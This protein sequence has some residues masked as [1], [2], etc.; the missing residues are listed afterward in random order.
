MREVRFSF[1]LKSTD[2]SSFPCIY[3]MPIQLNS[4]YT[5]TFDGLARSGSD[6]AWSNHVTLPGWYL[7]R[8]PAPGTEITAYTANHGSSNVGS[9]MSYGA[10]EDSD[11]ALGALGSGGT[12][13][14]SPATGNIA[15]WIA[16]AATNATGGTLE[17]ITLAFDGE[18][19][20]NGGN[21]TPQTMVLEYGFGASFGAVATWTAPG[22]TF[23][24]TSPIATTTAG[25]VDGNTAGRVAD[26][27]GTL[28]ALGWAAGETLW[29]RWREVNDAG[30][31]HGLAIDN[32]SL[33]LPA[34]PIPTVSLWVST[35]V[36][37]EA[38][39]TVITVTAIASAA[40]VG[41]QSVQLEV[42]GVGITATDYQLSSPTI[43]ILDGQTSGTVTFT[44]EDDGI[45]EGPEVATLTLS[46]PSAGLTLGDS[47]TQDIA[48]T[49][50]AIAGGDRSGAGGRQTF[51]FTLGDIA[52]IH[53]FGGVGP[54]AAPSRDRRPEV[55]TLVFS[56]AGLTARNL[57]L[58]QVGSDVVV[59]FAAIASPRI[60]LTNIALDHVDN[61]RLGQQIWAN[62]QFKGQAR[63]RATLTVLAADA[64]PRRISQRNGV[65][66]LNDLDNR[67]RGRHDS[68]DVINGQGGNDRLRGRRGNDLLRGGEGDDRLWGN[69]GHDV[70]LGED[71]D[72]LLAG[73]WGADRL[74]GGAGSDTFR[75]GDRRHSRLRHLDQIT[76][77]E[78]G[79][80]RITAPIA[81]A[82]SEVAQLGE[83]ST[84]TQR[85]IA[86]VL[87]QSDF[88]ARG[89]ATFTLGS[90]TFLALNDGTAGFQH[91]R[92][93]L[94][95]I[96]GFTG[97]LSTLEIEAL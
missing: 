27:G 53:D 22:G 19:W 94:I 51:T 33:T 64:T 88:A 60:T 73:G 82:A 62:F 40:V 25:A 5:Q 7:F 3:P 57:Q 11:R 79:I 65:T 86:A 47:I 54:G 84:L 8:Q 39:Q 43:I 42:S 95:E 66:I 36:G 15:G 30:N 41:D 28:T 13:F 96:T 75:Y 78:I 20:R 6:N 48:I 31:D 23:D 89:A 2:P 37:A 12:Y 68:H 16:F 14:G 35:N 61:L 71:G 21:A 77:L 18:Q 49:D 50:N 56:G 74:T 34:V 91:R 38:E 85:A 52:T 63:P 80:D 72:D 76:D 32:F 90:R 24:W 1:I 29:L 81:V 44:L 69:R 46:N 83:V 92:D 97:N 10:V 93:G 26:R 55:D 87:T 67:V 45:V 59:S 4:T 58:A 9:F 17:T 70:L